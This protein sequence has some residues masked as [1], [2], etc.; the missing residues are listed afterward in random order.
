MKE[1][2]K[3]ILRPRMK[4]ILLFSAVLGGVCGGIHLISNGLYGRDPIQFASGIAVHF[5]T[6]LLLWYTV[7][8]PVSEVFRVVR[9]LEEE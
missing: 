3:V 1:K 8:R 7:T 5:A 2:K 4:L 6:V 9:V